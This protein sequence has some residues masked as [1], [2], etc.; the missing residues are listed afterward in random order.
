MSGCALVI[1]QFRPPSLEIAVW[2]NG[3]ASVSRS[4]PPIMPCQAS[5]NS[6]V[7]MPALGEPRSGAS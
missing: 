4:P 6:T 7:K 2:S 3:G 5:R 1:A